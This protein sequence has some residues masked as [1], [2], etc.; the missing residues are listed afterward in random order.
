MPLDGPNVR[1]EVFDFSDP[2]LYNPVYIPTFKRP[3]SC[4]H[5]FG[6]AGSGKSVFV[7]QKE[8]VLSFQNWRRNRKTLVARRYYNSL[9]QSCYSQ[10]KSIIYQWGVDDCFKFGTSPYY[11]RNLRTNV[12][13]IFLGLDDVQKIKSI[14][15]A[16]RGWVEEATEMRSMDDLNLLRDRLRGFRFTQWTL[17]YNPT[18]AE[19]FINKEIHIPRL[20]GH[21][22][23][24][25]TYKDNIKLLE[26]DTEFAVRLEAYKIT[27]PNH[28]RVYAQGM[29]GK[30][31]EGLLYPDYSEVNEL[32]CVPQAYGL[33]LGWNDPVAMCKV[34]L[35]DE[36][37]KDRKQLYVEEML[38][39]AKMDIPSFIQWCAET[40]VSKNIPIVYD[41]AQPGPLF[42]DALRAAGYW[43]I[44]AWKGQ[45]SVLAGINNV[46]KYDLRPV[47]GGKNL[48]IELNG[49]SWKNKNG[50]WL[51][52]PQRGLNH[53]LDGMRYATWHL[54]KP[55]SSGSEDSEEW[56]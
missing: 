43:V 13:F 42:A 26:I 9:G 4:L 39:A 34:A 1:E 3:E 18:D 49:H 45:G 41:H 6:S 48:F 11:I 25:T 2:G 38:Y 5:Y 44:E 24:K 20:P 16:D 35:V 40:G 51:D 28:W 55:I 46:K 19:H 23:F 22:I 47:G 27:N 14:Q 37:G 36:Y 15:G 7:A 30:R 10:L 54:T 8:I 56:Y 31:L 50:L 33:D 17:T 52:E 29:W 53:L 32:P 12:E 21:F